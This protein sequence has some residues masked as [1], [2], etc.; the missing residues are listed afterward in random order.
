MSVTIYPQFVSYEKPY[1]LREFNAAKGIANGIASLG[2]D[3]KIPSTQLP[4]AIASG[5]SFVGQWNASTNSPNL[6][7]ATPRNGDYYRVSVSG[8][9]ALSGESDWK[10]GDWAVYLDST[11]G[12]AKIDNSELVTSVA[13]RTGAVAL[14][15]T[16]LA[17]SAT[18]AQHGAASVLT[19]AL[20]D[21]AVTEGKL[22][23][24][25]VSANK[26]GALSVTTAKLADLNV[27]TGKL[28]DSA[29]DASKLAVNAVTESKIAD[30]AVTNLKI[31]AGTIAFDRLASDAVRDSNIANLT[32]SAGK[33][34]GSIPFSKLTLAAGE[35]PADRIGAIPG[36]QITANT[37]TGT[38]LLD[39]TVTTTELADLAVTDAKLAANA[40]VTSKIADAQVTAAK[41]AV[42]TERVQFTPNYPNSTLRVSDLDTQLQIK[43]ERYVGDVDDAYYH[44]TNTSASAGVKSG[45]ISMKVSLG[46]N[47]KSV[48]NA[49]I[50][51][52]VSGAGSVIW[53]LY[54]SANVLA[55]TSPS[56]TSTTLITSTTGGIPTGT[57]TAGAAATIEIECRCAP[58][59]TATI[60]YLKFVTQVQ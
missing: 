38:Q 44:F 59:D 10:Q 57:Y 45:F 37:L 20:A 56:L 12:W 55:F 58:G 26:L 16:D 25:S 39:G 8:A 32:I 54:D 15:F 17:G 21:S 40:V 53:R 48:I 49:F 28:A 5:M 18:A 7:T 27:T 22:A 4:S 33:L 3:G 47:L 14:N 11:N 19:A 52:K 9:T 60:G 1:S 31:A 29:V 41:L 46:L 51:Y 34:A 23:D 43:H 6:V 35:V 36:S 13:G 30:G 24:S 42:R 2:S 50:E